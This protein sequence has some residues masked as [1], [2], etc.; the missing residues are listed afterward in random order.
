M[1]ETRSASDPPT[2]M[3]RTVTPPP[4]PCAVQCKQP[5]P[6]ALKEEFKGAQRNKSRCEAQAATATATPKRGGTNSAPRAPPNT[7]LSAALTH[8]RRQPSPIASAESHEARRPVAIEMRR[9]LSI[10]LLALL[11]GASK[12]CE[13]LGARLVCLADEVSDRSFIQARHKRFDHRTGPTLEPSPAIHLGRITKR[14]PFKLA[15]Q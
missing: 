4:A 15:R 12:R 8:E 9:S 11:K 3:A 10:E 1:C 7:R 2:A 14:R 5:S 6:S 13:Q